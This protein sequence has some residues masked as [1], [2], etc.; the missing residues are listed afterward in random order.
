M[1]KITIISFL[2]SFILLFL[3]INSTI[4]GAVIKTNTKIITPLFFILG[5]ALFI[6]TFI[7]Y[8]SQR[9]LESIVIPTGTHE[10]DEKRIKTAMQNY[11]NSKQ[12]PYILVTGEIQRENKKPRKDSQQYTIYQELRKQYGLKPS[13]MIIEGKSKDTLENFLFSLKKLPSEVKT[14]KIATSPTQY[15]RFKLFEQQAK[16]QGILDRDF[17]I[18][19]LYT[20]ESKK[21]FLYGVAAYIKDYFRIKTSQSLQEATKKNSGSFTEF[22]KKFFQ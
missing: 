13:D 1:K 16:K 18:Q 6:G 22:L 8:V 7:L 21:E 12:K 19:P 20:Q 14:L 17:Q 10:A 3:S 11:S 9:S 2:I 15:W 5:L 4:T